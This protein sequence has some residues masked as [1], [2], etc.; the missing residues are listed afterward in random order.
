MRFNSSK[1]KGK[2]SA[3]GSSQA[4]DVNGDGI[5]QTPEQ[6]VPVVD[7]RNA[8]PVDYRKNYFT[9]SVGA[10]YEIQR[11]LAVFARVSRGA[12]FNA[13]R[14][15]FGGGVRA[16]GSVADEV[17]VSFVNQQEAGVKFR[18]GGVFTNLTAFRATPA[19]ANEIVIPQQAVIN[20]SYR[21]Y[22][23]EFEGGVE[24]GIFRLAAG[25]TYTHARI[26]ESQVTPA[27]EGNI[28]YRQAA[29]IFQVT[30]Q[31]STDRF[32]IGANLIGT[33]SSYAADVNT[34]K[35]PGYV[36]TNAFASFALTP[37]IRLA[38]NAQN[39]FN[40][41]AITEVG[42]IQDSVPANGI[43]SARAFPGRNI[44]ASATLRF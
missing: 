14:I 30:P 16:D 44:S 25:A 8:S 13:D 12:R 11:D 4:I 15:L 18:R 3:I 22:G 6:S 35:I 7:T 26:T 43:N 2:Y 1:A 10:N 41:I 29:L 36:M 23:L 39:L 19:E 5:L 33:T 34:L 38:V 40:V 9:Y 31:I 24:Q 28:P 27:L 17:A 20:N 32:D 42:Q 37:A 21:S